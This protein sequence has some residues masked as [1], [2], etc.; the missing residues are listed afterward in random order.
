MDSAEYDGNSDLIS[1][2]IP[3]FNAEETL[4]A[5]VESVMQ[6]TYSNLQIILVDDGSTDGSPALCEALAARDRR[7]LCLHQENGGVS[8]ARN[9]GVQYALGAYLFFLDAD[10][11][12][13][14]RAMEILH[15]AL[16][17]QGKQLAMC[18]IR[19]TAVSGHLELNQISE[20]QMH[21]IQPHALLSK[22][23]YGLPFYEEI[24]FGCW[25]KLWNRSLLQSVVFQPVSM[26]EDVLFVT[27][28]L[29]GCQDDIVFVELPLYYYIQREG[30]AIHTLDAKHLSDS[31]Q[32]ALLIRKSLENAPQKLWNASAC[33]IINS[34]F[35]AF[36]QAGTDESFSEVTAQSMELIR[37]YRRA[38][39]LDRYAPAKSKI[40]IALSMLSMKSVKT[41]YRL[42]KPGRNTTE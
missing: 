37:A 2:I 10:D 33:R 9:L 38:V 36:L 4:A 35:F 40:A 8:A 22:A 11:F 21:L 24:V 14:H 19:K 3:L 32:S 1:V 25:G 39:F 6:Q 5:S 17:S 42:M 7:V 41:A 30:S 28:A 31:L 13:H 12:L 26:C 18:L 15:R 34:A 27:Q 29:S 23:L 16:I 20:P